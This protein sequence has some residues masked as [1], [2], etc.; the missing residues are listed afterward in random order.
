[1]GYNIIDIIVLIMLLIFTVAGFKKG[2]VGNLVGF[3]SLVASVILAW[4]LYPVIADMLMGFGIRDYI[5]N[6][7]LLKI[8]PDSAIV[9]ETIPEFDLKK[10]S[11]SFLYPAK[12]TTKLSL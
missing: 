10:P 2:F 8:N 7:V 1:M 9:L 6:T 3:I 4:I 5:Y 11:I 12:I